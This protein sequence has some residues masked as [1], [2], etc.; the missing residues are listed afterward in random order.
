MQNVTYCLVKALVRWLV[1]LGFGL[2]HL[3]AQD[4][5][6]SVVVAANGQS[7]GDFSGSYALVLGESNY[8][9]TRSWPVLN[10]V[11]EDVLQ[12]QSVLKEQGFEVILAQDL[13]Y[14][15]I[16]STIEKFINNYGYNA[17]NRLLIYY[18]GHGYTRTLEDGRDLGYI[19]PIDAGAPSASMPLFLAKAIPMQQFDTWARQM[20]SRHVLFLFD[21]CFSGSIFATSRAEVPPLIEA[22]TMKAVR[23]FISSGGAKETVPDKSV[24]CQ[25]LVRALREGVGDLNQ[26]GY[27]TGSELG[28][29]LQDKVVN[30]SYGAQHP[31]F[32]TIRDINLDQGDFVFKLPKVAPLSTPYPTPATALAPSPSLRIGTIT[33]TPGTLV[34]SMASAGLLSV[35]GQQVAVP[36]GGNV[37]IE[38]LVPA[39]Y[40]VV[41][42]YPDGQ[43]EAYTIRVDP[44]QTSTV[45]FKY[46]P[47]Q[48]LTATAGMQVKNPPADVQST[49][50]GLP[51]VKVAGG[52]YKIG[53]NGPS[54]IVSSFFIG[55]TEVTW[56]QF[57][58]AGS[59]SGFNLSGPDALNHPVTGLSWYDAVS[60]CNRLSQKEGLQP[61]YGIN[62][63]VIATNFMATGFR[64][65]TEAEWEF[66]AR[67]GGKQGGLNQKYAGS[68]NVD[69]VAWYNKNS[70][71]RGKSSP[72][73]GNQSVAQKAPNGLGIYDMSGNVWEWCQ[74][75][76]APT[77]SGGIDPTGPVSGSKVV[78]RGGSWLANDLNAAVTYRL[79]NYPGVRGNDIGLRVVRIVGRGF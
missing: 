18:S 71:D 66:A 13:G 74:D 36:A 28:Y 22:K 33:V 44:G 56:A 4:R 45:A 8:Q 30:Y 58:A 67:G 48:A 11:R 49:S 72:D 15:K 25:A 34:V 9:N 57:L 23:Q 68:D 77:V 52:S 40:P 26:D 78:L 39:D 24:F 59:I 73:Y 46:R 12:I 43:S 6:L 41:L 20:E 50:V 53:G 76:Y 70:Y 5:G 54:T 21:S 32:G 16:K 55:Q 63:T 1:F 60:F 61:V 75:W 35:A 42:K 38:G 10:G 51:L 69:Q 62:G 64:L 2:M 19:V 27:V 65:P 17:K 7:L 3:V 47:A 37:P 79:A 31:Q 14:D 29:F